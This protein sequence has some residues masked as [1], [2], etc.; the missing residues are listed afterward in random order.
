VPAIHPIIEDSDEQALA[1]IENRKEQ[2]DIDKLLVALGRPFGY[3]DFRQYPLDGPFPD[4]SHLSLNSYKGH[5][6]RIL[7]R[8]REQNLTVRQAALSASERRQSF[9]GSPKTV[10]D[11][12][13][14][15]FVE[16]AADGF[17]LHISRP[18]EFK[19]FRERVVPILQQRGLFKTEY[20][21]D[22]LRGHL[23]LPVPE[24]RYSAAQRMQAAE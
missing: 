19:K 24:N 6:E 16:R 4:V 3:H 21:A 11:E 22:T 18:G 12:I 14:R 17:N 5:A 15:W 2:L 7:K 10:A 20:F 8:V 1:R 9:V 13:E 23:G